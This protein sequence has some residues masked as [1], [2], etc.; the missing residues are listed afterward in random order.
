MC[1]V[2]NHLLELCR[3]RINITPIFSCMDHHCVV[4]LHSNYTMEYYEMEER[5]EKHVLGQIKDEFHVNDDA[6]RF[7]PPLGT[8]AEIPA[9][10]R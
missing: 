2:A 5:F 9:Y 6:M 8:V 1:P 4:A 3:A 7:H 10:A